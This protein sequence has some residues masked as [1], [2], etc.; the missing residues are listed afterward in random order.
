MEAK[1]M[2]NESQILKW[3]RT[4]E[5]FSEDEEKIEAS[6]QECLGSES[7]KRKGIQRKYQLR[8]NNL[9]VLDGYNDLKC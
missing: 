7:E 2:K 3:K 6:R 1:D 4:W 9:E 5:K 8:K